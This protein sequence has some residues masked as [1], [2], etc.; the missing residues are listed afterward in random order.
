MRVDNSIVVDFLTS[1]ASALIKSESLESNVA[2]DLRLALKNANS[3]F[4][5]SSIPLLIALDQRNINFLLIL[6]ARYGKSGYWLNLLRYS[7]RDPINRIL[8]T[9]SE[10]ANSIIDK[11]GLL[12]NRPLLK[13]V[14]GINEK[15]EPYALILI[16]FLDELREITDRLSNASALLFKMNGHSMADERHQDFITDEAVAQSLGFVK[17]V[18]SGRIGHE[19]A[20]IKK[21]ISLILQ[22]LAEELMLLLD[23]ITD[24]CNTNENYKAYLGYDTLKAECHRLRYLELPLNASTA[25]REIRRQSI[26]ESLSDIKN[27]L[28]IAFVNTIEIINT[29]P[30]LEAI[31]NTEALRRRIT[32]E[33]ICTGLAPSQATEASLAFFRYLDL[34]QLKPSK[35]ISSELTK[36]H[37]N[38]TT[39]SL[40]TAVNLEAAI[41]VMSCASSIKDHALARANQ[42]SPFFSAF[43][44]I[45]FFILSSCGLKTY[46]VNERT[47][48]RPEIPFRPEHVNQ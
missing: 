37:P 40:E 46:P 34:N 9:I 19:E 18:Y 30:R 1:T 3:D 42:L 2:D 25:I 33:L 31:D 26:I 14:G 13:K 32:Y 28:D 21:N 16:E 45:F 7:I 29:K 8:R 23:H 10:F 15:H 17:V 27:L 20:K 41:P 35:I 24:N 36:I 11:V 39:K 38:L 44:A 48:F 5:H 47:E 22:D 4:L 43:L 6:E 12:L